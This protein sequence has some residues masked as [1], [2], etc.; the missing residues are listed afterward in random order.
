M[1]KNWQEVRQRAVDEGRI[2]EGRV[3][4]HRDAQLAKVRAHRLAELR[5]AHDLTQTVVAQKLGISQPR[6]SKIESG[7]LDN[8]QISTLRALVRALGGELEVVAKVGD[9]RY[10]LA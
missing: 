7:E 6:L 4:E 5:E 8:T 2:N 3:R 10:T 9:E 1:A